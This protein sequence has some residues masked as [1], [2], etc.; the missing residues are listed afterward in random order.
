MRTT[1]RAM[2]KETKQK[3]VRDQ[4]GTRNTEKLKTYKTLSK[5]NIQRAY[6]SFNEETVYHWT[7]FRMAADR[8]CLRTLTHSLKPKV[9]ERPLLF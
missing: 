3:C 7:L 1:I 9:N 8:D 4:R 2:F 6:F 5:Q